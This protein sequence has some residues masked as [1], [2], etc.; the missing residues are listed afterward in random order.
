MLQGGQVD[1]GGHLAVHVRQCYPV[2]RTRSAHLRPAAADELPETVLI[3][4]G[5]FLWHLALRPMVERHTDVRLA[6][7]LLVLSTT[8]L[9]APV[10]V[11]KVAL[12][13]S[14][15]VSPRSMRLPASAIVRPDDGWTAATEALVRWRLP[16]ARG[17]AAVRVH[18]RRGAD[19]P[20]RDARPVGAAGG[21]PA[22]GAVAARTSAPTPRSP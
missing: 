12:L 10:A 15:P 22:A 3:S 6:L 21:L 13:G 5:L 4:T 19:R 20:H 14:G 18:P 1:L 9:V 7:G 8:C 17:R 11:M 2:C 16:G